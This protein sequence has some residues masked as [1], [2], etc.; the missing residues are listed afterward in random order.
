[1]E[2]DNIMAK[3]SY[4]TTVSVPW[5]DVLKGLELGIK[6]RY[7]QFQDQYRNREWELDFKVVDQEKVSHHSK[8]A[9]DMCPE[10][11]HMITSM[12]IKKI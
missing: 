1:M 12:S 5:M 3:K 7:N 2:R 10:V 11:F 6:F 9:Y 4:D 8:I